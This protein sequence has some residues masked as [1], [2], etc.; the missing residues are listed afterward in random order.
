MS[1]TDPDSQVQNSTKRKEGRQLLEKHTWKN[2]LTLPSQLRRH[3]MLG[4]YTR[5]NAKTP[6]CSRTAD[7]A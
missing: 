1:H 5:P 2:I 4:H 6:I 7:V 3:D